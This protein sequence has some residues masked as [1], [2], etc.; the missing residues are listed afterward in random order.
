MSPEPTGNGFCDCFRGDGQCEGSDETKRGERE[1]KVIRELRVTRVL[2]L[3]HDGLS[4]GNQLGLPERSPA[5]G[6]TL[7]RRQT[8]QTEAVRPT[9]VGESCWDNFTSQ[10]HP[11]FSYNRRLI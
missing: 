7:G 4:A 6:G 9:K 11:G 8:G 2:S 1:I 10:G 3:R 5:N